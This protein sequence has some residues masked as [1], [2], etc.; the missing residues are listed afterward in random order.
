MVE[1]EAVCPCLEAVGVGGGVVVV[2]A[3]AGDLTSDEKTTATGK[4]NL[5]TQKEEKKQEFKELQIE[6]T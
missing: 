5:R 1:E 4:G 3:G 6:A 2:G